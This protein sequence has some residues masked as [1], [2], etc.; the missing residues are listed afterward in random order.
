MVASHRQHQ[1]EKYPRYHKVLAS[2]SLAKYDAGMTVMGPLARK[3][4]G[5][6][7]CKEGKWHEAAVEYTKGLDECDEN[8]PPDQRGLLLANRS[9][10]WL[11]LSNFQKG[12]DDANACLELLP[13]HVKALFRRATALEKLGRD[14]EALSDF[15][16]VARVDPGNRMAAEA[17]KRLR[18]AVAQRSGQALEQSLPSRLAAALRTPSAQEEVQQDACEK[19]RAAALRGES[20]SLLSQG[21]LEALL[22]VALA[23]Q[24][25]PELR[26]ACLRS[27][28]IIA[29]GKEREDF[30]MEDSQQRGQGNEVVLTPAAKEARSRLSSA[31]RAEAHSKLRHLGQRCRG[32]KGALCQLCLLMS[33]SQEPEDEAALQL[34]A[35]AVDDDETTVCKAALASLNAIFDSRRRQGTLGKAVVFSQSLRCCLEAALQVTDHEELVH[36]LLA[37]VFTLL[38]DNN[39]RPAELQVDV[40][41]IGI[42]LLEP[43]LQSQDGLLRRNAL[44]G[45][46]CLL[47]TRAK[48]AAL[49]LQMS[50]VPLST[51]LN[52][53]ARPMPG[54]EGRE[55]QGHA[56]ECLLLAASDARTR[57]RWIDGGGIDVILNALSNTDRGIRRELVDAKLV[58]V[59]AIM[60]AHSKDVRD[61]IFDRVDFM[62]ELRFAVDVAGER[63][64]AA[65]TK[66]QQ[67][68]AR[69]LCA[70]LYESFAVL[71]MHG[72]F[73]EQLSVSKKTLGALQTLAKEEDLGEDPAISFYFASLIY[74]FCR[75]RDDKVRMKTGNPMI[76]ELSGEDFKALE[77]FYQRMPAEARPMRAGEVDAGPP[78]LATRFRS[79]CVDRGDATGAAPIVAKLC[80]C[81]AGSL[82]TKVLVA[83][84]LRLLCAD[85]S[86][87]KIVAASGGIRTLL[88]LSN[89]QQDV[90]EAR[91][92]RQDAEE[93]TRNAA[94]Q[95]LAQILIVLNP[96]FLQYQEQLDAVKPMLAL[97]EHRH[98]LLQFEGCLALTNLLSAS[99]ELRSFAL[100]SGAWSKCK[101]LLFS[102]HDE[103]QRA[104]LE[105]LCNMTMAEEVAERFA[106]GRAENELNIFGAFCTSELELQQSAATGALAILAG[107]DEVAVRIAECQQCLQGLLHAVLD[108]DLPAVE[109]RAV[110]AVVSIRRA[111]GISAETRR[112]IFSV[113][114][115]RLSRGGFESLDAQELAEEEIRE[116]S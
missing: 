5:N 4:A 86:D 100:Q 80:R 58:A 106:L 6:Q 14:T 12:L 46:A 79:W 36:G 85:Q 1:S 72:E 97:L 57:Q 16:R 37:E 111:E 55:S 67:R 45:L 65:E 113:L 2:A 48:D 18:V 77:D 63:A 81:A 30:E 108:S 99:E 87:R 109:I 60:A 17:A 71:A 50:A 95:A 11:K 112:A 33:Y 74:N 102:E 89:M 96:Q 90:R 75:S 32:N 61:E 104:G 93:S 64:R 88:A 29:S 24:T 114:Q 103:V 23:E 59:L 3:E 68:Q 43:F 82:Q 107:H 40:P 73:K 53:L 9:Q 116:G 27:L 92:S 42:Q 70:G 19:V 21:V 25:S 78:R 8:S 94:R 26:T 49:I 66:E 22:D 56:A 54:P 7:Y 101:D 51:V 41:G 15:A 31:L 38:A 110:S 62:M 28:C 13:E 83:D 44:A 34:L 91:V 105:A 76:D 47:A 84:C 35:E 39:D 69:R 52:A 10:C 98:E 20:S 115:E